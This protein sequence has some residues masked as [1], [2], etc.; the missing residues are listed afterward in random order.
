MLKKS[1]VVKIVSIVA[2]ILL[3]G[4]VSEKKTEIKQGHAWHAGSERPYII[5]GVKYYPQMHY[6]YCAVG[7]ASWYGYES[8]G[9]TATGRQFDPMKYTAAHRTLPLPCIVEVENLENHT[10]I[11]V[12][13]NDRGPFA[14]TNKR[15]IDLSV[16]A[17][18]ALGFYQRGYGK[19]KVTCIPKKSKIAALR[20]KRIPYPS[21]PELSKGFYT[22]N[23]DYE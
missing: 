12:L 15:I 8:L 6:Q 4:C 17:A 3:S 2:M 23:S 7:L 9:P 1:D 20:Y 10:R 13:V 16:A 11:V 14:Q 22:A 5:K 21:R 19:V 18:K